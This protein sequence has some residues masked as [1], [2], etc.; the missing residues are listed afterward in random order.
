MS[1]ESKIDESEPFAAPHGWTARSNNFGAWS[2]RKPLTPETAGEQSP[3][4]GQ[5]QAPYLPDRKNTD[6]LVGA[7][8]VG[9]AGGRVVYEK[10]GAL[11]TYDAWHDILIGIND[12]ELVALARVPSNES[13]SA[14]RPKRAFDCNSDAMAGFAAAHG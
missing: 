14:T 8:T 3:M 10:C 6:T 1:D 2:S 11:H 4:M 9:M 13:S 12:R 7:I 5:L